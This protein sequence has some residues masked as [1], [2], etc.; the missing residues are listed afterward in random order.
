MRLL[1]SSHFLPEGIDE[2]IKVTSPTYVL[3]RFS[4]PDLSINRTNITAN[5]LSAC[6]CFRNT[7]LSVVPARGGG[8]GV[9]QASAVQS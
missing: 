7:F 3:G 6:P 1:T 8:R 4:E 9:L 5:H 2:S